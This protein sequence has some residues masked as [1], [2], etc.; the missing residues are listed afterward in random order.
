MP[1]TALQIC[2]TWAGC[3]V[4]IPIALIAMDRLTIEVKVSELTDDLG[5]SRDGVGRRTRR[6]ATRQASD[7]EYA[8]NA[9]ELDHAASDEP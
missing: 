9:G 2:T 6:G 1:G 7:P 5:K 3:G 4:A 8:A